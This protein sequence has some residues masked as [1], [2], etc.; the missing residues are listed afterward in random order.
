M[1]TYYNQKGTYNQDTTGQSIAGAVNTTAASVAKLLPGVG[2]AV[3]FA[4]DGGRIAAK[5]MEEY[6]R[7]N[8]SQGFLFNA[9]QAALD[10]IGAIGGLVDRKGMSQDAYD[11]KMHEENTYT[12]TD[13]SNYI[14]GLGTSATR[15]QGIEDSV[16]EHTGVKEETDLGVMSDVMGVAG[17]AAG[18]YGGKALGKVFNGSEK[19]DQEAVKGMLKKAPSEKSLNEGAAYD[20]FGRPM[21]DQSK[22]LLYNQKRLV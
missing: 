22:S 18:E 8:G 1:A 9:A 20:A 10:P 21:Q 4:M 11:K 2:T 15:G 19:I 13:D 17:S 14:A 6:K 7:N 5:K 12:E 3:G 16:I